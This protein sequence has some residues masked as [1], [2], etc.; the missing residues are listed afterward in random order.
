MARTDWLTDEGVD[1]AGYGVVRRPGTRHPDLSPV[2]EVRSTPGIGCR[3]VYSMRSARS[4]AR[5]TSTRD[6]TPSLRKVLRRC[7]STVFELRKS[8]AAI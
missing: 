5:A 2:R 4:T 8:S 6:A 3:A 7:V 1:L